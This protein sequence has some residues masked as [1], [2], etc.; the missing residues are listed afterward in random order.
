MPWLE[1]GS[2]IIETITITLNGREVSGHSGM[3][4]LELARES[5]VDIPTLCLFSP[6]LQTETAELC[7]SREVIDEHNRLHRNLRFAKLP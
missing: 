2:G 3:T 6:G 7:F 1:G 4:V 5:G